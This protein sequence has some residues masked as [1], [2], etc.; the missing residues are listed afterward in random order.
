MH[1]YIYIYVLIVIFVN[2]GRPGVGPAGLAADLQLHD[3][4]II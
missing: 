2:L 3:G 1:I 4:T